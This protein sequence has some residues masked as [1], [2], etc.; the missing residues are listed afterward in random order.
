L[1]S[2]LA[3]R[4]TMQGQAQDLG[5]NWISANDLSLSERYLQAV[6]CVK[7]TDLRRVAR[8][9]LMAENRT[10]YA[11]LPARTAPKQTALAAPSIENA[12]RKIELP[13]GLRLLVK[14][15]H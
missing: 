11:L 6:K 1:S 14:E 9:C 2:T 7:S 13:N 10:L 4:K 5:A 8:E 12:I 3:T 15:D